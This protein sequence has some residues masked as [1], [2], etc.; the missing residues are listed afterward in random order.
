MKENRT[1]GGSNGR[2]VASNETYYRPWYPSADDTYP[3]RYGLDPGGQRFLFPVLIGCVS[4][5]ILQD[6]EIHQTAFAF[7][8]G[9]KDGS[10]WG[11]AFDANEGNIGPDDLVVSGWSGGF[12][13]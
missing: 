11:S 13:T 10:D 4:Y 5:E 12:V 7:L 1:K 6:D 8:I 3:A 9:R 2:M